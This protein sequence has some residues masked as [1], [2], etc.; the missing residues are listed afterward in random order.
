M[1]NV[2]KFYGTKWTNDHT[3]MKS[4]LQMNPY[5][6]IWTMSNGIQFM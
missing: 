5:M 1:D 4:G 6:N 3:W 2:N